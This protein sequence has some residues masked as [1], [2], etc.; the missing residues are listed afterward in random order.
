MSRTDLKSSGV[1]SNDTPEVTFP[2]HQQNVTLDNSVTYALDRSVD[3]QSIVIQNS[4][5]VVLCCITS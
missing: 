2:F 1:L 4:G 5:T 3:V